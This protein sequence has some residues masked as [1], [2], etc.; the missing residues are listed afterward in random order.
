MK[1]F[2]TILVLSVA[3]AMLLTACGRRL[4]DTA[5]AETAPTT[6][7]TEVAASGD[8]ETA[9]EETAVAEA[10][11]E[12]AAAEE[13]VAE[14]TEAVAEEAPA[15]DASDPYAVRVSE[16]DPANGETLFNQMTSTGF[17]CSTCHRVDS[18]Q[19]LVGPGMLGIPS[20]AATR[21]EGQR[22]QEYI[23]HSIT[24][25]ND[26]IVESYPVGV[27]PQVYSDVFTDDEIY[28]IIAYL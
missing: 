9:A 24:A 10:T 8:N 5:A 22:A 25:P 19:M 11:A 23:Y 3:L 27:M 4:D 2:R 7:P 21:V 6:A 26:Y 28:D 1:G 12:E 20:R 17:A 18:D 15:V 14:A 13:T 16:S